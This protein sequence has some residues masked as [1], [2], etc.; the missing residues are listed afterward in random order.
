MKKPINRHLHPRRKPRPW[1]SRVSHKGKA[2]IVLT[3][4]GVTRTMSSRDAASQLGRSKGGRT[5]QARGTGHR[6]TSETARA[7]AR[8]LWDTR[9]PMNVKLGRRLGRVSKCLPAV[10]RAPLREKHAFSAPEGYPHAAG[11]YYVKLHTVS[12]VRHQW[13]SYDGGTGVQLLGERTALRR[14]GYLRYP[15]KLPMPVTVTPAPQVRPKGTTLASVKPDM[16][17]QFINPRDAHKGFR[18]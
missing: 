10:R 16:R 7:A 8:K 2:V 9:Y 14:L 1:G 12:G 18:R 17:S 15:R 11:I 13:V 6:Y 5:A 4:E 3:R